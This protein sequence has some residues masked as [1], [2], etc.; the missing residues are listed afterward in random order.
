L[1]ISSIST[2][3]ELLSAPPHWI[4]NQS[5]LERYKAILLES[6]GLEG[7]A[8]FRRSMV[9]SFIVALFVTAITLTAGS[10]AAYTLA[11]IK[12]RGRDAMLYAILFIYMLPPIAVIIPLYQ[13]L[14]SMGLLD[15]RLSLILLHS[16][17]LTPFVI[18]FM[19]GYF[20]TIPQDLEDAAMI[21]GCT[22]L[23]AF[24]L[25]ILPLSVPGLVASGLFSILMSW[26]EFF[27]ALIFTTDT[28]KTIPVAIAEFS[29][30]HSIDYGMMATGGFLAS[31]PPILIT[32]FFQKYIMSGLLSG[33]IKG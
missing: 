11:R 24:R 33:S 19:R 14:N 16:A 7:G 22:L 10:L 9:N 18:W 25:V 21:D 29:G 27:M 26:E 15:T 23:D 3:R 32:L 6:G 1:F 5:T 2:Q 31:L 30:R 28:A 17:F 13:I 20:Q 12:V 4:P 8:V